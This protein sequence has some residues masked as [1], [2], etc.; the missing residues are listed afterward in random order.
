MEGGAGGDEG[1]AEGV[2]DETFLCQ[3]GFD[4]YRIALGEEQLNHLCVFRLQGCILVM[5]DVPEV[6]GEG[7]GG[8]A[9]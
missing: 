1:E 3:N 8:Y 2:G 6:L 4:A 9:Y 5:D 7:V